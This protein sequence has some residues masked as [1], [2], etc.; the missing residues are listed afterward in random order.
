[1]KRFEIGLLIGVVLLAATAYGSEKYQSATVVDITHQDSMRL[2][3][4]GTSV[5]DREYEI[6]VKLNDMTYV[7]SYWPRWRW[8]YQPTDLIV[9][10]DVQVRFNK[11]ELYILRPDGKE[12]RTKVIKR[13]RASAAAMQITVRQ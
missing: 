12:L 5:Q 6:A 4:A 7:G 9:N 8:S 1:M 13:I 10:S 3:N 11:N 2:I